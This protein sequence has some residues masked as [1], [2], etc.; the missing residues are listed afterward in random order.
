M[1]CTDCPG[2]QK[3]TLVLADERAVVT[4]TP[5]I[6]INESTN[7]KLEYSITES[8]ESGSVPHG[9]TDAQLQD[10]AKQLG[11]TELFPGS[12]WNRLR[13]GRAPAGDLQK[14]AALSGAGLEIKPEEEREN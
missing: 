3:Q 1:A 2:Q 7:V 12:S 11:A 9:F 8:G 14:K 4:Y 6:R 10:V 5:K 13:A